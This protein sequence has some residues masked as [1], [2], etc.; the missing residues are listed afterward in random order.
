[1]HKPHNHAVSLYHSL[2]MPKCYKILYRLKT[3]VSI[4]HEMP[5]KLFLFMKFMIMQKKC[6]KYE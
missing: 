5:H 4:T 3:L 2:K 6:I 1:M